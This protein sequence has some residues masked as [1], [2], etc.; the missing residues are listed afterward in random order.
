MPI[1]TDSP[2]NV[3]R[4]KHADGSM[5]KT[6]SGTTNGHTRSNGAHPSVKL[7]EKPK[8]TTT[9]YPSNCLRFLGDVQTNPCEKHAI[10]PAARVKLNII[11]V[12]AG[13]GGLA[14]AIALRRTGHDV[15]VFEQAPELMEVGAGIQVPPNSGKLLERWGVMQR[16][17]KQVVEPSRINF[18]RWQD[19]E[20]I[21]VTDLTS[22]FNSHYEVPYYVVHRAHLHTA[23]YQQAVALGVKTRLNSKV[24]LYEPDTATINLSDGSV[25]QGD[26]VVA[27]D[28]VKS[29]ARSIVAPNGRGAPKFTGYA[30][31]R[32][33]VDVA[34]M[35]EIPE[36][37]WVLEQPNLN[38]WIGEDKH[39]MTYCIASGQA[40]NMV[41]SHPD[42]SGS[43]AAGAEGDILETMK[44]EFEGWHPH[45]TTIISL[46]DKV[47]KTPLMSGE[48]LDSWVSPSSKLLILGDAA[49][50]MLPY[51][52]E[53]A[54]MAVEDGAAL[55][56]ALSR[57]TST[58][59]LKFALRVFEKERVQRTGM[60]QEASMVNSMIWHFADGPLQEARDQAMRPEVEGRHFLSSPNQWSD[61]VTQEWAY[62]YDA[63]RVMERAWEEAVNE[64]ICRSE[65]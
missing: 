20:V 14:T 10:A 29:T 42:R 36:I 26:L 30:V 4:S 49:H 35:R 18:R 24:E 17:A 3:V 56:V 39:V 41:L 64:L 59:Q 27:A 5:E 65:C 44:K 34:K 7:G 37:S 47:M 23:L 25:F 52:S 12:G 48:A 38:L 2:G 55:A 53:G 61:P 1:L 8:F 58:N 13:L 6:N 57:I 11:I 43:P 15:T 22:E 54:A 62:G 46:I 63:E 40:F 31:Y 33:T 50:A 45:L 28:G 16:L 32:A 51:M 9:S 19:S 21:G 60:M